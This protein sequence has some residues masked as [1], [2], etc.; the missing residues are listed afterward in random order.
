[1]IINIVIN[2]Y[3]I[4]NIYNKSSIHYKYLL[5]DLLGE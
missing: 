2:I 1:M 3:H 4:I 5:Y